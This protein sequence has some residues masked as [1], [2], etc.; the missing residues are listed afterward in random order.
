MR[1]WMQ[2]KK[3]R[4]KGAAKDEMIRRVVLFAFLAAIALPGFA[5][6]STPRITLT[7]SVNPGI[8]GQPVTF[9]TAVTGTSGSPPP[10]A[11][12]TVTFFDA[13]TAL[14]SPVKLNASGAAVFTTASL[15]AATHS[16]TASYS[17][18][19][20]YLP[21]TSTALS[22]VIV[23]A[24][25]SDYTLT[26]VST[27]QSVASGSSTDYSLTI[28]PTNGY[29]GTVTFACVTP[30]TG[31]T[32]GFNPI[33][34]TPNNTGTQL[35]TVLDV[36]TTGTAAGLQAPVN[37]RSRSGYILLASIGL[38]G[39][40]FLGSA[41]GKISSGRSRLLRM[42]LLVLTFAI[43]AMLGGCGGSSSSTSSTPTPVGTYTFTVNATGTAGTN[44]GNTS[45]HQISLTLTVTAATTN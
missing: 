41:R 28:T 21:V 17:G 32:C 39:I 11:T 33:S 16:I 5:F 19:S 40:V 27:T 24:P 44:G 15:S 20:N 7:S 8:A 43:I 25:A 12:G 36:T 23:P 1:K 22:E 31:T 6:Q 14:Y 42:F 13:G 9:T 18:D 29:N 38:F 4:R 10:V 3:T 26:A 45:V 37:P 35:V 34:L 30:P 2:G